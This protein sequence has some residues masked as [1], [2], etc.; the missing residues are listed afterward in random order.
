MSIHVKNFRR[1]GMLLE[2]DFA[3][4]CVFERERQRETEREREA[5]ACVW[6]HHRTISVGCVG[7]C[8]CV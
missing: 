1:Y 6:L 3:C 4:V 8:V 5:Y 2:C 7:V